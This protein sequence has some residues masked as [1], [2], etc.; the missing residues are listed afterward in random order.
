MDG[1]NVI[2]PEFKQKPA[3]MFLLARIFGKRIGKGAYE[4]RNQIWIV[5]DVL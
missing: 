2:Y 3:Y 4:W 1:K 5:Q